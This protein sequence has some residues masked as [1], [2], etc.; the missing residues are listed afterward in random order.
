[1]DINGLYEILRKTCGQLRKGE[2]FEGTPEMVAWAKEPGD[3]P[4][5]SGVLEVYAMPRESDPAFAEFEKVDCHFVTVAVNKAAAEGEREKLLTILNDWPE[6]DMLAGGPSYIAVGGVIGDQGAAFEL[7]AL[8]KVLGLWDVIT[9]E[10]LGMTG[11]MARQMAG[12]GFIMCTGYRAPQ[13][14]RS[15]KGGDGTAPFTR[16]TVGA[17]DAPKDRS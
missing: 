10:K 8:G 6:P 4:A 9:P 13:V 5:P 1:M 7:F 16:A 17:A 14:D 3:D 15:P 12:S 11:D 2:V